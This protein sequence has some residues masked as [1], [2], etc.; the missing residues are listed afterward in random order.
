[1]DV[2]YFKQCW[3]KNSVLFTA[4]ICLKMASFDFTN[5]IKMLFLT[6]TDFSISDVIQDLTVTL[7]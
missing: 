2:N 1:M 4:T 6:E 7:N 3:N 5:F